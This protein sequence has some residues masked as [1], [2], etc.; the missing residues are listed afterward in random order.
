MADFML[1][2]K[3]IQPSPQREGF[4]TVPDVTLSDIGALQEV[5]RAVGIDAPVGVF[6]ECSR[7]TFVFK[8]RLKRTRLGTETTVV[9]FPAGHIQLPYRTEK[10]PTPLGRY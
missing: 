8:R 10:Y 6:K 1:T 5:F 9:S 2:L 4:A 7:T 3:E